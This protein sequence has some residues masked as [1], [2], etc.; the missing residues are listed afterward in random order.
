MGLG[1][2]KLDRLRTVGNVFGAEQ[3]SY[4][5]DPF[6]A[7][8]EHQDHHG[9]DEYA[10]HDSFLNELN[11]SHE[12]VVGKEESAQKR[13]REEIE[14][15]QQEVQELKQLRVEQQQRYEARIQELESKREEV[16]DNT[17][18]G[19]DVINAMQQHEDVI[20][21]SGGCSCLFSA[22]KKLKK[23]QRQS[24]YVEKDRPSLYYT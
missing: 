21:G 5:P 3:Q 9:H 4:D 17:A 8:D 15:L 6:G 10:E 14:R 20:A 18:D 22:F 13:D 12:D 7:E 23:D 16:V 24:G 1:T 11:P 19:H 2:G